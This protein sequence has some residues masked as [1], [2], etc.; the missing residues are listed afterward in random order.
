[1][2]SLCTR[3]GGKDEALVGEEVGVGVVLCEN[4]SEETE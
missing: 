4:E 3:S 2:G 1:M